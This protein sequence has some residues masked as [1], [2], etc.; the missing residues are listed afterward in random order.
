[1]PVR[2]AWT[3]NKNPHTNALFAKYVKYNE[4]GRL[5]DPYMA[6]PPLLIGENEKVCERVSR[7]RKRSRRPDRYALPPLM[8]MPT[9][10]FVV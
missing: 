6:L 10:C 4:R 8:Q 3:E 2:G 5:L 1:M 7:T 9:E